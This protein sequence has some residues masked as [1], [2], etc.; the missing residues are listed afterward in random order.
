[1]L[2]L[3]DIPLTVVIVFLII[4]L[5][6]YKRIRDFLSIGH[7]CQIILWLLFWH[8]LLLCLSLVCCMDYLCILFGD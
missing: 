8:M 4:D 3:F 7:I 5:F 1:M 2:G 6:F